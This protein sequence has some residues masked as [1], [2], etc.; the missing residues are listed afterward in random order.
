MVNGHLLADTD[1]RSTNKWHT[2]KRPMYMFLS[3]VTSTSKHKNPII[4]A[5]LFKYLWS[6]NISLALFCNTTFPSTGVWAVE[7][8]LDH[9]VPYFPRLYRYASVPHSWGQWEP[10][11]WFCNWGREAHILPDSIPHCT[12]EADI[13]LARETDQ[14]TDGRRLQRNRS[15][16]VL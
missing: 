5:N 12:W 7:V 1:Q 8:N 2:L 10:H 15:S 9:V 16:A 13:P 3:T 4:A 11:F 14:A 6:E